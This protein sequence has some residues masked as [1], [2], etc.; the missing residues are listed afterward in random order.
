MDIATYLRTGVGRH[1]DSL[2]NRETFDSPGVQWMS[3][4]SGV[5]HAE[6][7]ANDKGTL[8]QGF[9][10]WI[11]V[12]KERKMDDPRYGTVP[13]KDLPCVTLDG[14]PGTARVLAGHALGVKGPF[15]TVQDVQISPVQRKPRSAKI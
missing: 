14:G 15:L 3:V 2:G 10:I 4:G 8:V 7:G 11:N 6:G 12:P 9:Q 13:S 5:E 1:A